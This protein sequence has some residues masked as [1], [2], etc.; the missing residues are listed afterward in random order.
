ME[1]P[2]SKDEIKAAVFI[3]GGDRAPGLDGFPIAF[4]QHFWTLLEDE[5]Q[6]FYNE[7]HENGV[8][9]KELGASF[10]SLIPKKEGVFC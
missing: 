7:F 1:A 3:L 2:F 8:V 5:F 4:F 6:I 10:I 9:S